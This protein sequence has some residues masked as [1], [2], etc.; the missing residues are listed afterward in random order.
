LGRQTAPANNLKQETKCIRRL[1]IGEI[2]TGRQIKSFA[3]PILDSLT[4]DLFM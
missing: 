4:D 2:G 1:S 3:D